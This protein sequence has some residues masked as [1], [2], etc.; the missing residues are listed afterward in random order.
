LVP[1]ISS[2]IATRLNQKRRPPHVG[3]PY[4]SILAISQICL[5]QQQM[6]VEIQ[7]VEHAGDAEVP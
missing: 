3:W 4:V 1:P 5:Q 7:R 6:F 2:S